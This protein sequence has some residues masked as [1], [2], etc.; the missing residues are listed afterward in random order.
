LLFGRVLLV[1]G[2]KVA[3]HGVLT[4]G[5]IVAMVLG[6]LMLYDMPESGL[7]ISWLVILPTVGATAGV[8]VL[9]VSMGVRALHRT[10]TTGAMGMV[11]HVGVVRKALDPAGQ[12]L[13]D[14][15]LWQAVA[16]EGPV[17]A[18]E[19]VEIL[20]VDGLTLTVTKAGRRA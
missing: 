7:R 4:V 12:V 11:G 13:V 8:V 16:R 15:E 5:G 14:G 18:G 17:P 10:P 2:I 19:N 9:A 20:S 3:S 1:A 6:S